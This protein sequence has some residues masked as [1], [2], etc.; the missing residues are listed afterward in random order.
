MATVQMVGE[1]AELEHTVTSRY[2]RISSVVDSHAVE[3]LTGTNEYDPIV[4]YKPV[5]YEGDRLILNP[6]A[7]LVEY[8]YTFTMYGQLTV[9]IKDMSGSV[10]FFGILR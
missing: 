3:M 7:M 1:E 4:R 8:P 10:N 5:D 6:S 2:F 9:A